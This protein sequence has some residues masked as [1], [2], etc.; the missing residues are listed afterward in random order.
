MVCETRRRRRGCK[1][2]L[3]PERRGVLLLLPVT[4]AKL[5]PGGPTGF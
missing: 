4:C 2:N 1:N 3:P 5:L